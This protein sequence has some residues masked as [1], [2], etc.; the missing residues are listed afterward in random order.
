MSLESLED[1]VIAW[2]DGI[3]N[4]VLRILVRAIAIGFMLAVLGLA[5]LMVLCI[6]CCIMSFMYRHLVVSIC[7]VIVL[8]LIGISIHYDK[9]VEDRK[10]DNKIEE[11]FMG[12]YNPAKYGDKLTEERLDNDDQE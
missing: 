3:D 1:K 12:Y 9:Y 8:I 4:K 2:I 11:Q 7:L 6:I 10:Q 5:A